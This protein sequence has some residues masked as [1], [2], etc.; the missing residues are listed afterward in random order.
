MSVKLL[1]QHGICHSRIKI[2]VLSSHS[3]AR[4]EGCRD[5]SWSARPVVTL[6]AAQQ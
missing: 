4:N 3:S 5:W 2:K 1:W 6:P